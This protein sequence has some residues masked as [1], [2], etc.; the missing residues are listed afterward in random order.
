MTQATQ[1]PQQSPGVGRTSRS[2][3]KTF[4]GAGG[5]LLALIGAVLLALGACSV[6]SAPERVEA[7]PDVSA[8]PSTSVSARASSP[9]APET[10][11]P[12]S[13]SSTPKAP[14]TPPKAKAPRLTDSVPTRV[15][16]ESAGLDASMVKLG[17]GDD[18]A[19][20]TPQNPDEVGWFVG[21][22]TP[23][24]PG[25]AVLA[26]HVTWN[27]RETV[28]FDLGRLEPGTKISVDRQDGTRAT[29]AVRRRSTFP[30][31]SFPTREVYQ[32]SSKPQLVL[33]TCGGEYDADQRYYDSNVIVWAEFVSLSP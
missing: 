8:A 7:V 21:A 9:S 20:E 25:T 28:F 3:T 5:T 15:R 13:S 23:G 14:P 18:G 30:K 29:F 27:G 33:I 4:L 10:P 31:D 6:R 19:M 32:A 26:G 16:I 22:H 2:R 1:V 24:G 12:R 17:I 11:A